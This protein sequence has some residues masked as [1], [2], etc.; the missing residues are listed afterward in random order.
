MALEKT[1]F[2]VLIT[3][4]IG[5]IVA[6]T[7][8]GPISDAVFA[9][10]NTFNVVNGTFT[11]PT[12]GNATVDLT[13]RELVGS[14]TIINAT[15]DGT[16]LTTAA[17]FTV[18]TGTGTNGLRTVQILLNDTWAGIWASSP[19]NITYEYI[20]DGYVADSGGRSVTRLITLFAALALVVFVIVML[21]KGKM[22]EL[23]RKGKFE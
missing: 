7:F 13:G 9:Q 4:F 3:I 19:V 21:F 20:P 23:I 6:A 5:V 10:T 1:D 18:L 22:G 8:M 14:A 12:A 11:T 2:F 17:N 15:G 16:V